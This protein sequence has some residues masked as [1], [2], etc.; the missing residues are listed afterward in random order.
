MTRDKKRKKSQKSDDS[1]IYQIIIR[2]YLFHF[3]L[4]KKKEIYQMNCIYKNFYI[5]EYS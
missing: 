5:S 2:I 4:L 3:I 1:I